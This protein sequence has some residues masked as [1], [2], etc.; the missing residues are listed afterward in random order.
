MPIR[1]LLF[2]VNG[3]I[4]G[5]QM[6]GNANLEDMYRAIGCHYVEMH[7]ISSD[8]D[9]NGIVDLWCDEE[10]MLRNDEPHWNRVWAYAGSPLALEH[11]LALAGHVLAFA[12]FEGETC[13]LSLDGAKLAVSLCRGMSPSLKSRKQGDLRTIGDICVEMSW[14]PSENQL[15]RWLTDGTQW[16]DG[17]EWTP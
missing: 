13:S 5:F 6:S 16:W 4:R 10:F 8:G 3:R 2:P 17:D 7:C 12:S 9:G 11:G 15:N 14:R 1:G